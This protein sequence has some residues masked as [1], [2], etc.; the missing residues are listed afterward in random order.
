MVLSQSQPSENIR[1]SL[2]RKPETR[3]MGKG[4]RA[5][6]QVIRTALEGTCASAYK[7]GKGE[8]DTT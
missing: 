5:R 6:L 8:I 4:K 7:L 3:Q 2:R 1:K